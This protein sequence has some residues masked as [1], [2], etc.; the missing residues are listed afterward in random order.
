MSYAI[1][2]T[3]KLN[4]WGSIGGS[5][6]HTMRTRPTHNADPAKTK[7][8]RILVGSSE[9]VKDIQS[10]VGEITVKPRV[11]A[12]LCVEHMLT[13]SP[14][15]KAGKSK[16]DLRAWVKSNVDW[17][18]ETYGAANVVHASL[19]LDETTPH[20]VAYVVP[21]VG[22]KLNCRE[23]LGGREKLRALQTRYA[24][25]MRP[26]GLE[27]GIKGSQARH[28]E[29]KDY[30]ALV[31]QAGYQAARE[32]K[33][34]GQEP[35]RPK[36]PLVATRA[37]VEA[38][39]EKDRAVRRD[40]VTRLAAKAGK[41]AVA[42]NEDQIEISKLKAAVEA[43]ANRIQE[44]EGSLSKEQ[45]AALRRSDISLVAQKLGHLGEVLKGENAIDLVKRV[46]GFD[47]HQA[48]AWLWHELGSAEA[49]VIVA[50][51]L[52]KENPPRPFTPAENV[53][54]AAVLKQTDALGCDKYRISIVPERAGAKPYLPGK[55]GGKDSEERFYSRQDL[56]EM[57]P[58]LRYENNQGKHIFITPMDDHAFYVL[59]DDARV[60]Q[61]ELE[62]QGF[63]PCLVQNTSWDKQQ[64]VFKI[65][66]SVDREAVLKLFNDLNKSMGDQ[67]MT[68]LRH[69]FR[70]AGFR[71]MKA[72][73]ERNGQ[74]P[75]VEI[76]LAVN[77]FCK[78]CLNLVRQPPR[79]PHQNDAVLKSRY[80]L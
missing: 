54:K 39:V 14:E 77:R 3:K 29:V 43:Q 53:I 8:N 55:A 61:S 64:M 65:P 19:H 1:L 33:A 4:N 51:S 79:L 80:G 35:E 75:F 21:E 37:G 68:G 48:V 13:M 28:T 59:L 17:L 24:A 6:S 76:R 2:R 70:L 11:N 62:K 41:L 23:L 69:P 56:I 26:H 47:Y 63:E 42:R 60:T 34:L 38:L 36:V 50:K 16:E 71:N 27:R 30:Y 7:Y 72:K 10:R 49:G 46:N 78:K 73:H 52:D 18:R 15:W 57:I 66:K 12:V 40:K 22:G 20:I 31:R 58:W 9:I 45:I 32:V 74:R 44:L 67:E 25:M 5:A